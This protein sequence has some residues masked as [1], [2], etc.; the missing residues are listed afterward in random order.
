MSLFVE[1][2]ALPFA[3]GGR[4]WYNRS[5]ND[6]IRVKLQELPTSPGVYIMR[7]GEGTVVYVGKASNLKNRVRSY[8][9]AGTKT[10]KTM[11]LVDKV[12]D[13]DYIICNSEV[14]ALML[15]NTLIKKHKPHYN[16]LLKDDKL[17][18]FL[19]IDLKEDY[20]RVTVIRRLK[21]DGAKY[22]GPYMIGITTAEMMDLLYT[23]FPIRH[24]NHN[25]ARLPRSHRPCLNYHIGQC[26]APCSGKVSRE[27]YRAMIRD[28][29]D[30]LH[31]NDK[32]VQDILTAKM[33]AASERED[34]EVALSYKKKLDTLDK[35]I[36]HQVVA[37]PRDLNMDVWGVAYGAVCDVAAVLSVRGGKVVAVD[38]VPV[39]CGLDNDDSLESFLFRYYTTHPMVA[40]ELA[41]AFAVPH[42][43]EDA[44]SALGK[45]VRVFTPQQGVRKQL[46]D[47]AEGNAQ[48]YLSRSGEAVTRRENM[49]VGAAE[50]LARTI[51]MSGTIHRME[52]YDI[53]H[54]S[55]TN[56]VGSMVVFK[57]GESA[58]DMYRHFRIKTVE[59][60]NDFACMQEVLSRRLAR[61]RECED[62]SFREVPDLL[63][64]DGGI[65]QVEYALRAMSEAGYTDTTVIGLAKREE[66]IVLRDGRE[67]KLPHSSLALQ[68]LQR[69]RDEAHR[70]AITYHRQLRHASTLRSKLLTIAGVGE[71]TVKAL[72]RR[73][74]SY[75]AI[76]AATVEELSSVPNMRRNV[77]QNIY[78]YFHGED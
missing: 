13:F 76:A 75:E 44:L 69:I 38:K 54:I 72:Y 64:I 7:D 29:I 36:R 37:L 24:C 6:T 78:D 11:A 58:R 50:Q 18:P 1:I 5:M 17:Y 4:M 62:V 61:L 25:F 27:A 19:R 40:E 26:M 31:G 45:R 32:H 23:A 73:F 68:L 39:A 2:A 53:S 28:V 65:I 35:M 8:F 51:G 74:R 49:T 43:L 12:V 57:D 3:Y 66:T 41:C 10:E 42:G 22:F 59:G 77:A 60:N 71:A 9:H 21:A 16:I 70:F 15:E 30:F 52:C 63:V 48:E 47:M 46:A 33:M 14:D 67:I 34:Y 20:P 55:G 56:K